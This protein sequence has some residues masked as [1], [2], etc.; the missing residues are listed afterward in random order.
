MRDN[1]NA[2]GGPEALAGEA[3]H[4]VGERAPGERRGGEL[5][6]LAALGFEV[7]IGQ[8]NGAAP[9]RSSRD[10]RFTCLPT[11]RFGA[12]LALRVEAAPLTGPLDGAPNE[13]R[14]HFDTGQAVGFS[15]PGP[16]LRGI[17]WTV[18]RARCCRAL[19]YFLSRNTRNNSGSPSGGHSGKGERSCTQH[20]ISYR[21]LRLTLRTYGIPTSERSPGHS[22]DR[23]YPPLPYT[24]ASLAAGARRNSSAGTAFCRPAVR[25][26]TV[27]SWRSSS[28]APTMTA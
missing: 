25:F 20:N 5:L 13:P 3:A 28:S 15:R 16:G 21:T 11:D 12:F 7:L 14:N 2:G 6:K 26:L 10:L 9:Q 17:P 18:L 19:R 8:A 23:T 24:S 4:E 1:V 27:S 22:H